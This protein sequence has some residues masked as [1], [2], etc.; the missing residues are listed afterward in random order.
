M[1]APANSMPRSDGLIG[2]RSFTTGQGWIGRVMASGKPQWITELGEVDTIGDQRLQIALD[3]GLK[4]MLAVPVRS[5]DEVVAV[6]EFYASQWR[7]PDDH[8][9]DAMAQIGTQL[10]RVAERQRIEEDLRRAKEIAEAAARTKSEFLANMSH[11]IRTPV[12]AVIGMT[13]LL[14][15]TRL[16]AQQ[17]DFFDTI[18]SSSAALLAVIDDILDF[19]KIESGAL[20][21]EREPF[22]LRSCAEEALDIITP[23]VAEKGLDLAY[24]MNEDVPEIL[25][26]DITRLRQILVN[27]LSNAVKFTPEGGV[28]LEITVVQGGSAVGENPLAG[29]STAETEICFAVRDTGIGIPE[30]RAERLF[31]PFSQVDASTTRRYGGTGLGLVISRNLCELMGGRIWAE[32]RPGA[33]STFS[34]TIRAPVLDAPIPVFLEHNPPQLRAKHVLLYTDNTLQRDLLKRYFKRW[35][36]RLLST[37]NPDEVG[38]RVNKGERFD[39]AVLDTGTPGVEDVALRTRIAVSDA[40]SGTPLPLVMLTS[41]RGIQTIHGSGD[42]SVRFLTVPLKP[43]RLHDILV[44]AIA[45]RPGRDQ[46]NGDDEPTDLDRPIS[47]MTEEF[48]N[49]ILMVE[50]NLVN[51]KVALKMLEGLGYSAEVAANGR[52]ALDA[53]SKQPFDLILMDIQMPVLDGLEASKKIRSDWPQTRQPKI[54]AMTANAMKE[55]RDR[56]LA[57]GMDHYISKPVTIENLRRVLRRFG[58]RRQLR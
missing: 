8:L 41:V 27:L 33:G 15:S 32:S 46:E 2:E 28:R 1:S 42:R 13:E 58:Q 31:R 49:G 22:E 18:R 51:Q 23:R 40:L 44:D 35:G 24:W 26:G 7:A 57:A 45:G 19:S 54:I 55:D 37:E 20:E 34:F 4:P 36:L 43:Q 3:L 9:L 12:N 14:L 56:C 29:G 53:L 25:I 39:V 11:E 21:L 52:E 50:D 16:T 10:G 17:K 30:D 5:E 47:Q 6:L 38:R 48:P